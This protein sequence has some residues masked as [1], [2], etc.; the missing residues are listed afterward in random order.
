MLVNTKLI[1]NSLI[2]IIKILNLCLRLLLID[3]MGWFANKNVILNAMVIEM[4]ISLSVD[5]SIFF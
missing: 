4:F 1:F 5:G 2:F 3:I